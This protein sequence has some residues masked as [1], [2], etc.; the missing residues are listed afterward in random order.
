MGI[1]EMDG[2]SM[3]V[4]QVLIQRPGILSPPAVGPAH[5][6]A[7][8]EIGRAKASAAPAFTGARCIGASCRRIFASAAHSRNAMAQSQFLKT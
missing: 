8:A 2:R 1:C 3:K 5:V 7:V 6:E 4:S